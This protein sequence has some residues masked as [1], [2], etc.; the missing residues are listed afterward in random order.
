MY[1]AQQ[2]YFTFLIWVNI[3]LNH[4]RI[5]YTERWQKEKELKVHL[6]MCETK[7]AGNPTKEITS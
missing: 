3:N 2:L 4:W 7:L 6:R 1:L 5:V